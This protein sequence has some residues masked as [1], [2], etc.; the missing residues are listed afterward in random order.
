MGRH[1]AAADE[2][3]DAP[4]TPV[5]AAESVSRGR[6]QAAAAAAAEPS[7]Q[8][9]QTATA[10]STAELHG[11]RADLALLREQ[12]ALRA[13]C[14]AAVLAPFALYTLVILVLG[15]G[16]VYLIW[17]WIPII[18]VGVLVGAL[19]DAAHKKRDHPTTSG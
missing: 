10:P 1:S 18:V 4:V 5:R 6:H 17:V 3:D 19:L 15:H 16:D 14:L 12:P 13:R 7:A 2:Q 9:P 8:S 11:S